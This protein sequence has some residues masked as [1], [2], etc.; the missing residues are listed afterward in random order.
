M[1]KLRGSHYRFSLVNMFL[2]FVLLF[3]G[4]F[5]GLIQGLNRAG[6]LKILNGLN[7]YELL[8]LHGI[9]L[10]IGFTTLFVNGYLYAATDYVLG[11]LQKISRTLSWVG[12]VSFLIG[13]LMVV[14]EVINHRATVMYTFYA[15]MAAS[16]VFYIGLVFVVLCIWLS[17]IGIFIS[18]YKWKQSHKGEHLPLFAFFATGVYTLIT[19]G[20]IGVTVE[21]LMMIPWSMGIVERINV[22]LTR[23]LFWSFGHTLVNVW[24]LVAVSAWYLVLP[25]VIGGKVY[26][27]ALTRITVILIVVLN[28]PGGFHHQIVDP[29]FSPGLKFMHLIMSV[30]IGFPSLMTAFAMFAVLEQVGRQNGGK[31]LLGWLWKL[32]WGD[33][34]FLTIMLAMVG[35]IFGGAGGIAQTNN[36]LN[37]VVHNSLWIV[38]HFHV[39]V[40]VSVVLT[41]FGLV[42]WLIPYLS[43]RVLTRKIHNLGIWQ[44][45]FWTVGM[46]FMS[47]SMTFVGLIGAPRRTQFTTYHE[48]AHALAWNPYL[49]FVGAG[50]ILLFIGIVLMCYIAFYLMF[51]AP[52]GNTAFMVAEVNEAEISTPAWTEKWSLWLVVAFLLISMGYVY[53]IVDIIQ[54]APPGSPP[55]K[56]W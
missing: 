23:T 11:G 47:L 50:G 44:T 19:L 46:I 6:V 32:P 52:K 27:D 14:F 40:G 16:P 29:G 37:Q 24:Y 30:A 38:G 54:N 13:A 56:T 20:S 22:L 48:H 53:P 7:Y 35:F 43:G 21:V 33:V 4:G 25:K 17:A 31:G 36:Q 18:C 15:P 34:R 3:I 55:I 26:S 41:F 1:N 42:Y 9:L 12:L 45:G 8:T 49:L 10:I 5:I 2:A 28:V 51:K 39:T